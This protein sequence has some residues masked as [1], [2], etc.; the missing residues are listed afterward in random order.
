M[1]DGMAAQL[2][3]HEQDGSGVGNPITGN[4]IPGADHFD[5]EGWWHANGLAVSA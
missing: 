2:D 1:T 3:G 4:L 5:D